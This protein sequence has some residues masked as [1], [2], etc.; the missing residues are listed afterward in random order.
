MKVIIIDDEADSITVIKN[1]LKK[2][3][4]NVTIL[5]EAFDITQAYELI[6]G[7][8]PDAVFL[9][10]QMPGGS[11]FSLLK[12][13][14]EINF[15]VV[16]VTSYDT[17]AIDAI[18]LSALHYLLKPIE[19]EDLQEAVKRI[20]KSILG[21][22]LQHIQIANAIGNMEEIEKK[23]AIHIKDQVMLIR[24]NEIT[25]LESE[26]NYTNI[27]TTENK[28]Y[29]SSKNLGDYE[30][31]LKEHQY[32]YRANKGCLV[33]INHISNYSKGEPCIVTIANNYDQEV[34]RRKKQELLE[35]LK[36]EN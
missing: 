23:I 34:S 10:I 5:G 19:V 35:K 2:F 14:K 26:R 17:Y 20:E 16:F 36:K 18:K 27:Y 32:F 9:D 1:L 6:I 25:H 21:R 12:K 33:N 29:T 30:E 4:P 13:F 8:E 28:K 11:G 31:M 7:F 15:G 22:E 3:C 24:L